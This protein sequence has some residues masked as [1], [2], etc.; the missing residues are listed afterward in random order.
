LCM[1]A[2][3]WCACVRACMRACVRV[4]MCVCACACV[5]VV[6]PCGGEWGSK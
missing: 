6:C 2:C 5:R 3:V 1:H 4:H